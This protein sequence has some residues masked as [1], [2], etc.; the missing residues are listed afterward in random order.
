MAGA[1]GGAALGIVLAGTAA[2]ILTGADLA[3]TRDVLEGSRLAPQISRASLV[4]TDTPWC[5]SISGGASAGSEP[6]TDLQGLFNQ[7]LG[8]H[9]VDKVPDLLGEDVGNLQD[10][11]R[12]A[13]AGSPQDLAV[14]VDTQR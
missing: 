12:E 11:V 4:S 14:I 5:S 10:V 13:L 7:L 1:V 6:C 9:I 3:Q 2:Y 8:R